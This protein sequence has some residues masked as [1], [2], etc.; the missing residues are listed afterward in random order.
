MDSCCALMAAQ[1]LVSEER[2]AAP[3]TGLLELGGVE[4]VR[5]EL[6]GPKKHTCTQTHIQTE[7]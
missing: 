2:S 5:Q 1:L 7:S 3:H 4:G 6:S